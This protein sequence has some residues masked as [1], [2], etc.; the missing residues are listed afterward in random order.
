MTRK[1]HVYGNWKLHNTLNASEE[2]AEAIAEGTK[3]YAEKV[4]IG[5]APVFTSLVNV[6]RILGEVSHIKLLGQ[7]GYPKPNGAFTGEVSF[8]LLSDVGCDG[9]LVGHSERRHLFGET[10]KLVGEK[11]ESALQTGLEV[12]L[13]LGESLSEREEGRT[14]EVVEEQLE[15]AMFHVPPVSREKLIIAYEPVWAIGTGKTATPQQ[16]QEVHALIRGKIRESWLGDAADKVIILY[17]GSVN[18]KNAKDLFSQKDID[19]ALVGG[20]SLKPE[21]FI[22]IIQAASESQQ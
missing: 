16:A 14:W 17:G 13:C 20:A 6:R 9:V 15:S 18:D 11:V 21:S 5:V 19:G 2:L 7:N 3:N 12:I 8:S 10:N 1:P 22:S 4:N